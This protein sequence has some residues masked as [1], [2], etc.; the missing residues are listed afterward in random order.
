MKSTASVSSID[1]LR[2][3]HAAL[4]FFLERARA[5]LLTCD[6][7]NQRALHEIAHDRKAFWDRERRRREE[8]LARAKLE[9]NQRK[10]ARTDYHKP[11]TTEQE[12]AI[13]RAQA[14]LQE[15]EEKILAVRRWERVLQKAVEE[16]TGKARRLAALVEGERPAVLASLERAIR[17]LDAYVALDVPLVS[18]ALPG[19]APPS[20]DAPE[21][22][23]AAEGAPQEID[24][25][26]GGP[27][28]MDTETA[29]VARENPSIAEGS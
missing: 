26:T 3:F 29:P 6:L 28:Q 15:A 4:C 9:L 7:Q 21:P 20:R 8:D 24:S 1:A 27:E 19:E 14:R 23:R 16:Y 2:D 12:K 17:T 18:A 25:T 22:A 5:G 10:I 11:D 13:R